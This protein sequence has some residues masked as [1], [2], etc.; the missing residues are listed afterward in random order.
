MCS[1]YSITSQFREVTHQIDEIAHLMG[2][3]KSL[4]CWLLLVEDADSK[5]FRPM[6]YCAK[7]VQ[8]LAA[9]PRLT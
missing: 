2:E 6:L 3:E 7:S 8:Y 1:L 9:S 4:F 5:T